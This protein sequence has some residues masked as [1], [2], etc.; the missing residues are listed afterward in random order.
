MIGSVF[1]PYYAWARRSALADPEHFCAINV[2][3]YGKDRRAWAMTERGRQQL[4]RSADTLMIGPSSVLWDGNTLTVHIDERGAP[5]PKRIRGQVRVHPRALTKQRTPLDPE[6]RH[7]WWPIAPESR[8]EVALSHPGLRWSG[9]GYL[10]SNDGDEPLEHGFRQWDWSRTKLRQGSAVLYDMTFLD[11]T[12]RALALRFD[13]RGAA[14]P[15]EPPPRTP[16]KTTPWWR[17]PRATQADPKQGAEILETLEDTPFYARSML[18]TS[19]LG[20]R[21]TAFH[22]SLSLTRFASPWVQMLLPFRMPRITSGHQ[23][24]G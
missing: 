3:L 14:A 24:R 1:S 15:F 12:Q 10:D 16:L 5:L 7:R 9:N 11:G 21:V 18:R 19:L 22:E 17:I 23:G 2:A 6:G 8:V 4:Y 13:D 20:E